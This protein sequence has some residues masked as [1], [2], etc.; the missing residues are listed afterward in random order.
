[1]IALGAES[2]S[3]SVAWSESKYLNHD[4]WSGINMKMKMKIKMK[5]KMR[6]R[7][8]MMLMMLLLLMMMMMKSRTHG[9]NISHVCSNAICHNSLGNSG[10]SS[11]EYQWQ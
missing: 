5:M 9:S 1:M 8:R 7:M 3:V 6:M 2:A 11:L 4:K 10:N